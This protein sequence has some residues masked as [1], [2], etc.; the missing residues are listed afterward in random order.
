MN[1]ERSW[2][3]AQKVRKDNAEERTKRKILVIVGPT[4]VGKT[5]LSLE[6]AMVTGAQVI[7]ADSR[8][9]YKYM[10]IGTDK[11][12]EEIRKRI[13]HYM[14]DIVEPSQDYNV[15]QYQEDVYQLLKRLPNEVPLILVGG[16]GFYVKAVIEGQVFPP[17][18]LKL[19][20]ELEKRLEEDGFQE[21]LRQ[22]EA[23]DEEAAA[24]VKRERNPRRLIRFLEIAMITGKPLRSFLK[25]KRSE[26]ELLD[27]IVIGL[28]KDRSKL[29]QDINSRVDSQIRRGLIEEVSWLVHRYGFH[30]K[31]FQ[32]LGYQGIIEAFLGKVSMMRAI[33]LIK[34]NTRNYAKRQI[35]WFKRERVLKWYLVEEGE[36]GVKRIAERVLSDLRGRWP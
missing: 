8:Q 7:S 11:V 15:F 14:I 4:C 9:V 20:K 22:L 24:Q 27:P 19:R 18:D 35:S 2:L 17:R 29:Y 25:L 1:S 12:G 30:R 31:A 23:L 34:R 21:L 16:T 28:I 13:P 3:K 32:T 6:L 33:E 10:D 26:A 5:A 36:K